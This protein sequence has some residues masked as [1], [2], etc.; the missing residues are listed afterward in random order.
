MLLAIPCTDVLADPDTIQVVQ[1]N[2]GDFE[3]NQSEM[4]LVETVNDIMS[5]RK[6]KRNRGRRRRSKVSYDSTSSISAETPN[7]DAVKVNEPMESVPKRKRKRSRKR[8]PL[9]NRM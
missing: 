9:N 2:G 5:D 3:N 7:E 1:E 8:G 6:R 4:A